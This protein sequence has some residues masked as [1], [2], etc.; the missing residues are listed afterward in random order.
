MLQA[1]QTRYFGPGNVKGSR[2]K[3]TSGSG[4]SVTVGYDH[5]LNIDANHK[6][7]CDALKAKLNWPEPMIG[8]SLPCGDR[9][10]VF[11]EVAA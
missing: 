11:V 1:I 2:I 7:A 10:W 3:A 5:A 6:A 9:A 8:G 4:I